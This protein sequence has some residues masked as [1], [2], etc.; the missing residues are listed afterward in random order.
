MLC[1]KRLIRPTLALLAAVLLTAVLGS[2]LQTHFNLAALRA[3]DVAV[4]MAVQLR[5]T[6]A[7]LLGFAPGY[8]GLVAAGFLVAFL[9]TALLRR[10]WPGRRGLWFACAG[11]ASQLA[12]VLVMQAVFGLTALSIA[13]SSAGVAALMLAGAAGGLLYARLGAR[14]TAA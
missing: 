9:A 5:T 3:L 7:D 1:V 11:A 14:T 2:A 6:G 8:A 10:R 12:M 13:R 4:P